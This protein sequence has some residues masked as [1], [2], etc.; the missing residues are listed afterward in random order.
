MCG[1]E[2]GDS[3]LA[4][5]I[6]WVLWQP[7][8]STWSRMLTGNLVQAAIHT[9]QKVGAYYEYMTIQYCVR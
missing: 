1:R 4:H 2:V 5:S 9:P 8:A 3:R 6:N 7:T